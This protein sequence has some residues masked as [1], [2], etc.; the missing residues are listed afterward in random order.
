MQLPNLPEASGLAAGNDVLWLHNDSGEPALIAVNVSGQQ[1]GRVMLNGA[2][3]D[4]WEA[5]AASPCGKGRCLF[6]G[7]IG[8][9]NASRKQ[10][11]V[12]R[13]ADILAGFDAPQAVTVERDRAAAIARAI[14]QAGPDDI[15]LVAGKGHEPYQDVAGVKHPFDDTDVARRALEAR[16]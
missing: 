9:N 5:L 7:D 15:V 1:V 8:D 13:L 14:G 2:R 12:Y 6:V 11:T 16:A 3:V 4:D 10:I